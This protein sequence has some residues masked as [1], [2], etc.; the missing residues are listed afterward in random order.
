[1]EVTEAMASGSISGVI[2]GYISSGGA[3]LLSDWRQGVIADR[4]EGRGVSGSSGG[5]SETPSK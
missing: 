2:A 3:A 5:S 1:M 4:Q